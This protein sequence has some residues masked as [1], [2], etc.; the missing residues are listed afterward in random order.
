[1]IKAT[2]AGVQEAA[3]HGLDVFVEIDKNGEKGAHMH[4]YIQ[5]YTFIPVLLCAFAHDVVREGKMAA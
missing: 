2:R 4:R 1:M 5:N 3:D